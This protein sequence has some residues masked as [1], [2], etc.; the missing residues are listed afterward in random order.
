MYEAIRLPPP[1]FK[2]EAVARQRAQGIN[3]PPLIGL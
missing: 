1:K 3:H 2:K